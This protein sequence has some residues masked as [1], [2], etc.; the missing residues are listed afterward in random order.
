MIRRHA[1]LFRLALMGA[2]AALALIVVNGATLLRFG[3]TEDWAIALDP[4]IPDP[5]LAVAAFVVLWIGLLW[6]RGLYKG[7]SQWTVRAE[8]AEILT[9][10][11]TLA[12]ITLSALFLLKLPDVSRLFLLF[13]FPLLAVAALS[14][15]IAM[16]VFLVFL[17]D[18][19]RNTR[20]MLV[21]GANSRAKAFAD[22]VESHHELGLV[23]IGHLKADKTD[24]GVRLRRPVLGSVDDLEAVLHSQIVDEVAICL[25]F[26]R[27]DLIEQA[28]RLC[29]QEGKVVRIPVTPVERTLSLGRMETIDGIGVYSLANGPDRTLGLIAKRAVDLLGAAVLLAVLSPFLL[30]IAALV[31]LDSPGGALFRQE[32]VG[33][34]G[35]TFRMIK[36]R[37]MC[38][39]AEEQL[40]SL[41]RLNAVR[42]HAFKLESDPRVTRVGRLLRRTSLD[43]LPQLWNVLRGQMSMVGPRPPLPVE[44]SDYDVWHRRRLSMKPG[45][46]GLWQVRARR[47]A[48][49]D[50]WV[51]QDLEYIDH[52]SLWL[53]F[54]IIARTVP[55]VLAGTGR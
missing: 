11:S 24:N 54:K 1:Y 21:L 26:A 48:E 49:F 10:A 20:F 5:R 35:R 22:L 53:D 28:A 45:M 30:L 46:T 13:V 23:V 9:A 25:P 29:E 19:G 44:V 6:F 14:V 39:D 4:A 52:W 47:S 40:Q 12:V 34:H 18:H 17:R 38:S 16:R 15:R 3:P 43:E 42:G 7:R 55:A 31:R 8:A 36:F 41:R 33:L 37:T 2:D 50:H 27:E 32:R 51:E